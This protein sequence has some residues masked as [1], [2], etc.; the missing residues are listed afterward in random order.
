[1]QYYAARQREDERW[2]F[3]CR[4]DAHVFPVGYCHAWVEPQ[5]KPIEGMDGAYAWGPPPE[6]PVTKEWLERYTSHKHRYHDNG[7][8]NKLE[9]ANCYRDFLL[10]NRLVLHQEHADAQYQCAVCGGWTQLFA[11]IENQTWVLCE[12]HNNRLNVEKL[13]I[14]SAESEFWKS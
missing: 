8:P 2:E 3:T 11:E 9:A 6:I 10:D 12:T 13:F 14:L 4:H 1:M 5:L 7:H